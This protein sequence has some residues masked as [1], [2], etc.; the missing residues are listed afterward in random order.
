MSERMMTVDEAREWVA[1]DKS[2]RNTVSAAR[3]VVAQAEQIETLS[4]L[5]AGAEQAAISRAEQI[6]RLQAAVRDLMEDYLVADADIHSERGFGE[7][8]EPNLADYGLTTDLMEP[9]A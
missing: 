8:V 4:H 7:Y 1:Q 5:L 9:P 3:T 6:E 2:S